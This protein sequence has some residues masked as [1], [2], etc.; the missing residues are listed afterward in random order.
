MTEFTQSFSKKSINSD[1]DIFLNAA[2]SHIPMEGWSMGTVRMV[3]NDLSMTPDHFTMLFPGGIEDLVAHFSDFLDRQMIQNWFDGQTGNM[4]IRDK[5]EGAV[6]TRLTAAEPYKDSYRLALAYW[7]VPPRT[8]RAGR[9]VWRTA[10]RIWI[11]A[12]DISTDYNRYTK[13]GLLASVITAT[14]LVWIKDVTPDHQ[15]TRVF[16]SNR[17]DNVL[18]LGKALGKMKSRSSS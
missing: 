5:I 1:R 7:S 11:S 3:C 10:D 4:R 13:R 8:V 17:I 14:T 9:V 12:G 15:V 2:L 6:L 18:Q 16:L